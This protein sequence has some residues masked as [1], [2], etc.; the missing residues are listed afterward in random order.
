[1]TTIVIPSIGVAMTEALLAQWLKRPGDEVSAG[2]AVAEIETDKSTMDLESPV[3]GRLGPHLFEEGETIPVGTVIVE[4]LADGETASVTPRPADNEPTSLTANGP[5]GSDVDMGTANV[6]GGPHPPEVGTHPPARGPVASQGR[7]QMSP[8]ARMLAAREDT[9]AGC[10]DAPTERFRDVIAAKVLRSWQEIPHF[11]VTREVRAAPVL[12]HLRGLRWAGTRPEPTVTDLML[13]ALATA[14][15]ETGQQDGSD[16]GLAVATEQGVVIAVVA[17]VLSLD[18]AALATARGA[19]VER[20]RRGRLSQADMEARPSSTLSNLGAMGIDHFTGVIPLDQMSLLTVGRAAARAVVD[21]AGE[22]VARQTFY[23]TLNVDHR[24][25][26]GAAAADIL[27]AFVRVAEHS[28]P[29]IGGSTTQM[30]EG[31]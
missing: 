29:P 17:E 10:A 31:T 22:I 6:T 16:V 23:A 13:R 18:P 8:R 7:R 11:A 9:T 2:D 30:E 19:A 14:L 5:A 20:A 3:A 24:K 1:M 12:D 21:D 4:I 25:I 28:A 26:D 27:M 15:V